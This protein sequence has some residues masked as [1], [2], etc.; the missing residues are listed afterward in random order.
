L[1]GV[2]F[3]FANIP[4]KVTA[5]LKQLSLEPSLQKALGQTGYYLLGLA[6]FALM[7]WMLYRTGL[8]KTK[9]D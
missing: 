3:A 5:L 9:L 8:K 2:I 4:D 1:M 6:F 7:G